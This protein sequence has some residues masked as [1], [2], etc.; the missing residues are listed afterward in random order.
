MGLIK[1][2]DTTSFDRLNRTLPAETV[3][4]LIYASYA[5][6]QDDSIKEPRERKRR[7][8]ENLKP[9]Y[10]IFKGKS[11]SYGDGSKDILTQF[12][13]QYT[14]GHDVGIWDSRNLR[15]SNFANEVALNK[16]T[17][18]EYL[19]RV[20][21]NLFVYIR[22]EYKHILFEICSFMQR[23]GK[24]IITSD[25]IIRALN[26]SGN[27]PRNAK[28]QGNLLEKYL[29]D[30]NFFVAADDK[31]K[32]LRIAPKY[33]IQGVMAICNLEY[34]EENMDSTIEFFN[35]KEN[36]AGYIAKPIAEEEFRIGENM[37]LK[38][39]NADY[40]LRNETVQ[41]II[42]GPPGIGKSF[43]VT[44][45]IQESYINF[46]LDEDNPFVFRT[47]LHPEYSYNDFIGQVMPVVKEDEITYDFTAGIFTQALDKAIKNP[48]NDVYLVLEEMSRAN[49]AAIFGDIF[50]LLDRNGGVSEYKV[51]HDLISNEIYKTKKKIFL[52]KNLHIIGTVNTSDQNVYVMDTA[53]KRRFDFEYMSLKPVRD[54]GIIL[55]NYL[56]SF[57]NSN[58]L[59][60]DCDWTDF[61]Q[62]LNKYIVK[63]LNLSEDK[64]IG[65]FFIK[66]G[67]DREK[68]KKSINNKLLQYLWQDIHQASFSNKSLFNENVKTFSE[69]HEELEKCLNSERPISIFSDDFL[70]EVAT[71]RD[72]AG[73]E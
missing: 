72:D 8:A 44:S 3:L 73:N 4:S 45:D 19:S 50:Q 25:D 71:F 2:G 40:K 22:G 67:E 43:S 5:A 7:I 51:N 39:E 62:V 47:T 60:I 28:D 37:E 12:D 65:Q 26:F 6:W 52:P 21:Q 30:T 46:R 48:Q 56:M 18:R 23:E 31:E 53:F 57:V 16:I 11:G 14:I 27:N 61:Y 59:E 69:A 70:D 55:N 13:S 49:V 36:F 9:F 1:N 32:E 64:Q 63:E 54:K 58:G 42:Y 24:Y 38:E 34:K 66:F 35:D 29:L 41:K 10:Q 17:I 15:L 20:F 33:T 68:N